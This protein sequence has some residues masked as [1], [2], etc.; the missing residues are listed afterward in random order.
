MIWGNSKIEPK[1]SCHYRVRLTNLRMKGL[2]LTKNY[3]NLRR[4]TNNG[5]KK[6]KLLNLTTSNLCNITPSFKLI[7]KVYLKS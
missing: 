2:G 1:G 7:L 5:K 4:V 3:K 6:T